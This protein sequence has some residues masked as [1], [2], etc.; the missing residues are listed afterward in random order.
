[1]RR[2]F[3]PLRIL[4]PALVW[5]VSLSPLAAQPAASPW[6][7]GDQTSF[8]LISAASAVGDADK[9]N[10]GLHFKMK[11]GWKI[12][13]RSP[14]DAGYPPSI[15]W[16]GSNNLNDAVIHWPLPHRF[17]VLGL[18]S[19]GYENEV[20]LPLTLSLS[21]PGQALSLRAEVDFLT[22]SDICI[23]QKATVTMSLPTGPAAPS[24]F[25][26]LI[27]RYAVQVPGDG[28]A[29][30]VRIE[31]AEAAPDGKDWVARITASADQPFI[32]PDIFVEGPNVLVFDKPSVRY[33]DDRRRAVL[34][35]KVWGVEDLEPPASLIGTTLIF[36]LGD[37][38]R[39]AEQALEIVAGTPGS[40]GL[41]LLSILALAVLGGLI[42]NLMPCVLPVLS[43]KLL[44]VVSH[45][46]G[47]RGV[48][49]Q[50][51]IAT[52][53]GIV[54]AFL[55]L[56]SVLIGLK[57][58]G[59]SIGWGIQFQ[60]PVF[61][62]FMTVVVTLF[63]CNLWGFFEIRLPDAVN[64]MGANAGR[65]PGLMGHFL[66][67]AFATVLATP[68]SA[69]F[70]GTAIGFALG[71]DAGEIYAV[72][73]AVG[74]GLALPYLMIAAFPGLA[75]RL[76]RPGAW[77]IILRRVLGF[78]LAATAVWLISVLFVQIGD[79]G[80]KAIGGLMLVMVAAIYL[81]NRLGRL[82]LIGGASVAVV[83]LLALMTPSLLPTRTVTLRAVDSSV[84]KG[85]WQPFAPDEIADLVASG[86]I[87]FV[88]VTAD[89]C[90]TCQINKGV[91]LSN[92]DVLNKL[93]AGNVVAMQAD[94]TLPNDTIARYLASFQRYGIPF[95]AIYGPGAPGGVTLPELL[96]HTAVIEGFE[97]ASG[98]ITTPK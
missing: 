19:I 24:P 49:R 4:V 93:R 92:A 45:G 44:G 7:E 25:G 72:F 32:A 34:S 75:T 94:W 64:D 48:V 20:V 8:R 71:R 74:I 14:G 22:C 51:F 79:L 27:S 35:A 96:S 83:T 37:G 62:I 84:F 82:W 66:T 86:K 54:S 38:E 30:G 2:F 15:D 61:L 12:Y 13:W 70:L 69:P 17:S 55:V 5:L 81:G 73:T 10:F 1:M 77:M 76:P 42:L 98:K 97:K 58:A 50:S 36:T 91:V 63:A 57:A 68:C 60:Q 56:A 85:I 9:L 46:G 6:H 95:N 31:K 26:H 59:M 53:A 89:W 23:P 18:E 43:I 29:H 33:S 90:L 11:P 80:G 52:S 16:A 21:N 67:G 39:A 41:T 65:G 3:T 40:D 88:D 87:V 47:D 28:S 78:A